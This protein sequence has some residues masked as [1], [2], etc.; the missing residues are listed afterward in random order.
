MPATARILVADDDAVFRATLCRF[1]QSE[2]Y[3]CLAVGDA[4]EAEAQLRQSAFDLFISDI[5]MPGNERLEFI[6]QLP[7]VAMGLP[8]ILLTGCPTVETAAASVRLPVVA[9]LTKPPPL[10]E[11]KRVVAEAVMNY[12]VFRA[13]RAD[14]Q[15]L[16]DLSGHLARARS[17]LAA[18]LGEPAASAVQRQI[19]LV[20]EN[21]LAA[22]TDF[23]RAG[24][25]TADM[26]SAAH[27]ERQL[28]LTAALRETVKVLEQTKRAFKS[29]Q[30]GALRETLERLLRP[31]PPS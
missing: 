6:R 30:L 20:L 1:L 29:R 22:L 9:Y 28:E 18:E 10:E 23:R 5:D 24:G 8:V 16:Q 7:Q 13:V 12:R 19:A 17:E 2:G 15:T 14:W 31:S 4:R 25:T 21:L 3:E 27:V 26:V 11:M